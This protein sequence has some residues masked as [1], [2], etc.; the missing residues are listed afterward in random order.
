MR[1]LLVT[2]YFPPAGGGGV[3]RPL[4][5]A[6]YLPALG[7]ETHVLAPSD[8]KW[9]HRDDEL[10]PPSQAWVH[11]VAYVG[12]RAR[13]PAEELHGLGGLERYVRHGTLAFRRLLVPDASV[14]WN[15]TAIPAALRII[16]R[17]RIDVVLT[18]SPPGSVHLV[19]AAAKKAT[20]VRWIADLRD[21]LIAH[22]H[23]RAES[24]A[25]RLK[26]QTEGLLGQG[27]R[28]QR[29]RRR[30]RLGRDRRRGARAEPA[31]PG[32]DDLER[33]RLRGLRRARVPARRPPA[34][35][36]HGQFLRQARPEA[37]PGGARPLGHRRRRPL[38]RR[39]PRRGPRV[40]GA[41]GGSPT[42]SRS[43][44]TSPAAA[45]SSSS[46]SRRRCCC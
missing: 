8:P 17:E 27:R 44:P 18:T 25:V 30:R 36:A 23:R 39:L 45:R 26:E 3:Q 32:G 14:L 38:R 29:R 46:A 10:E 20:G 13:R 31:R 21:S 7:I 9:I 1:L 33:L 15:A 12:P 11:R 24:A 37:V 19:G 28:R 5:F 40:G 43:S 35:H 2:M 34:H 6:T 4:K 42:A 22:P 16:R 41:S